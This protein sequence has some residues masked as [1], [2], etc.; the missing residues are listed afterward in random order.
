M[1]SRCGQADLNINNSLL[2]SFS[3]ATKS[4]GN[5]CIYLAAIWRQLLFL[6]EMGWYNIFKQVIGPGVL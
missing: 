6:P 4:M 5:N 1:V 2:Y 3:K